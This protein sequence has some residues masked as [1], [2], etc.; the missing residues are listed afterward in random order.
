MFLDVILFINFIT[1]IIKLFHHS[2]HKV[3]LSILNF[4]GQRFKPPFLFLKY[5]FCKFNSIKINIHNLR[6]PSIHRNKGAELSYDKYMFS[7]K[8]NSTIANVCLSVRNETIRNSIKSIII[9]YHHPH[10][11][12]HKHPSQYTQIS[13]SI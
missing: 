13:S 11:H 4:F 8:S 10:H 7:R 5:C 6:K 9:L 3:A 2:V 12:L 1:E